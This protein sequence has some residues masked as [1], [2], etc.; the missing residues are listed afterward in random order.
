MKSKQL[1]FFTYILFAATFLIL[2]APIIPHHHHGD[3]TSICMKNDICEEES[4]PIT[5]NHNNEAMQVCECTQ[6]D[7]TT[8]PSSQNEI[9]P[10]LFLT[11]IILPNPILNLALP[12]PQS[13]SF[14]IYKKV[15]LTKLYISVTSGL[16]APPFSC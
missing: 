2:L 3:A 1:L 10:T 13:Q 16:R 8:T 4:S 9:S 11:S 14:Y 15:L 5:E 6:T 7:T 12:K